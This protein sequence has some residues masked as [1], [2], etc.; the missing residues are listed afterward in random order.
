MNTLR[1]TLKNCIILTKKTDIKVDLIVDN[2]FALMRYKIKKF[3]L[4]VKFTKK[5]EESISLKRLIFDIRDDESEYSENT[6]F[7]YLVAILKKH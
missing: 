4:G 1:E 2:D 7:S 6:N 5:I 3:L